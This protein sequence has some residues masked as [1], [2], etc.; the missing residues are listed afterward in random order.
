[1][2]LAY[3]IDRGATNRIDLE[4]TDRSQR[5]VK[6]RYDW[7]VG[8]LKPPIREN[9]AIEYWIEVRDNNDVTGPGFS[10][11]EHYIARVVSSE[12]KRQDLMN[13]VGD[14]LSSIDEAASDQES[15]NQRLG[16]LI[17]ARAE[18]P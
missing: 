13:R 14:S 4:L 17:R 7:R 1:V 10:A 11:T 12:E 18:E 2:Q 15:L 16:D 6:R 3:S 5:L 8:D 9:N